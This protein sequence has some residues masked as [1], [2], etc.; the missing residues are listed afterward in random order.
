MNGISESVIEDVELDWLK[1][2]GRN[3]THSPGIALGTL[4]A[5]CIDYSKD[6]RTQ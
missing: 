1:S 4:G 3:I 6:V 5:E 2:L